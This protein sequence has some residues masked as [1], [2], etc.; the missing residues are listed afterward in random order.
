M[1]SKLPSQESNPRPCAPLWRATHLASFYWRVQRPGVVAEWW[2]ACTG[3]L[4]CGGRLSSGLVWNRP[5][6][7]APFS[8]VTASHGFAL[9]VLANLSNL[10]CKIKADFQDLAC[11]LLEERYFQ[12]I[13]RNATW[14]LGE[15]SCRHFSRGSCCIFARN[16]K[17]KYFSLDVSKNAHFGSPS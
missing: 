4:H 15:D 7:S 17:A 14:D 16:K 3:T 2:N 10:K 1:K 12:Q 8:Q 6:T 13:V 5:T 9:P 11:T